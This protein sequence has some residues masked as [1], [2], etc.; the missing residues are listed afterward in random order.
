[1]STRAR[2]L[3]GVVLLLLLIF[4]GIALLRAGVYG[5][6]IFYFSSRSAWEH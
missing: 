2:S 6:T 1:M 3:V 5:W 4:G